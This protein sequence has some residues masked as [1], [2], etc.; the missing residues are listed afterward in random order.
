MVRWRREMMRSTEGG[1]YQAED[2]G[3]QDSVEVEPASRF[4]LVVK[5]QQERDEDTCGTSW[6]R[7]CCHRQGRRRGS[8]RSTGAA[9]ATQ[10]LSK[11]RTREDNV[12]KAEE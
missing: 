11:K 5:A 7:C 12:A 2:I 8:W 3:D 1:L 10:A 9:R 6:Q 4:L